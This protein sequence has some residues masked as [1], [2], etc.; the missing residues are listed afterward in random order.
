MHTLTQSYTAPRT[1]P[2][3]PRMVSSAGMVI[4]PTSLIP[5][6]L[7]VVNQALIRRE[8]IPVIVVTNRDLMVAT[9]HLTLGG[10]VEEKEIVMADQ[11]RGV[12]TVTQ[13]RRVGMVIQLQVREVDTVVVINQPEQQAHLPLPPIHPTPTQQL[14]PVAITRMFLVDSMVMV[15]LHSNK[16]N[17]TILI[18]I[19]DVRYVSHT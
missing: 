7:T 17:R 8:E 16:G 18:T 3:H 10:K 5:I 1:A 11:V 9:S 14:N 12:G 15:E 2:L 4:D 6:L 13:V 19:M